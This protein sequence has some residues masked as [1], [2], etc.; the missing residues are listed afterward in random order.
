MEKNKIEGQLGK[1]ESKQKINSKGSLS[2]VLVLN[3]RASNRTPPFSPKQFLTPRGGQ[4]AGLGQAA[5]QSILS[6]HGVTRVLAEEGGR[7]SR[8]SI[9]RMREYLKLLNSLHAD[10]ILD[11]AKIEEWWINRVKAYFAAKPFK[12]RIDPSRSLRSIVAELIDAAFLRQRE[13][14]GTMIA[15]AVMQ[16]LVGAKLECALKDKPI[17]HA[18]F[19]VADSP[20]RRKGDFLVGDTAIHVTTAPT[21][22]L[23][24][25]C[26]DNLS[27]NIRPV[28]ITTLSGLGGA[29]ALAKNAAVEDRIDII[30]IEQFIATNVYEWSQ[31]EQVQ[32]PLSVK[33]L[34]DT[35][36]R[37]IEQSETDQSLKITVG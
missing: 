9:Q 8:G 19:S 20:G 34:V 4:V 15:G 36:N 18:G 21:E 10:G 23:V 37:I 16:H 26:C 29:G 14:P 12:L 2:L 33:K 32:R 24:R 13:C 1:F 35:Y 31:F 25:K 3:R 11:F 30:E 5:V 27:G 22:A 28:I 6:E 7:T 17:E